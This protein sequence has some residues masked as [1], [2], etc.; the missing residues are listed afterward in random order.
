MSVGLPRTTSPGSGDSM[1]RSGLLVSLLERRR[2]DAV[3]PVVLDVLAEDPLASGGRFRGD[4]LRALIE[5]PGV[6]WG[7][8]PH[9]YDRYRAA[10]RAG[11]SARRQLR[12][13]E[14]LQFWRPLD[15][16]ASDRRAHDEPPEI[17]RDSQRKPSGD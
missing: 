7:R 16:P 2:L 12:P 13:E 5:V 1:D 10:L 6:F 14:R 8:H 17:E 3:I 4:L 15:A 9:L 11:A